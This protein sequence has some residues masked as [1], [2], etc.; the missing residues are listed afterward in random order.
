M[1]RCHRL[2]TSLWPLRKQIQLVTVCSLIIVMICFR[3]TWNTYLG[4]ILNQEILWRR[5]HLHKGTIFSIG[6]RTL[7]ALLR[8]GH[9]LSLFTLR[10]WI[11]TFSRPASRSLTASGLWRLRAARITYMV[12]SPSLALIT[13]DFSRLKDF[14]LLLSLL[15]S[16]ACKGIFTIL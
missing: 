9:Q 3:K 13:F 2:F 7:W 1:V 16:N 5:Y 15:V 6:L 12:T 10:P 11:S 14:G 4:Y 8:S